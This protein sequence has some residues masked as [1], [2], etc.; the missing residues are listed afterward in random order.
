VPSNANPAQGSA[1]NVDGQLFA[2]GTIVADRHR[3]ARHGHPPPAPQGCQG[4]SRSGF[5][6]SYQ[7]HGSAP[8]Y[9]FKYK[10]SFPN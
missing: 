3:V 5:P 10:S 6:I 9:F 2:V 7:S 1:K 8:H 4:C